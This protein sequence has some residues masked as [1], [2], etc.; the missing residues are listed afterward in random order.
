M[1][2]VDARRKR[3]PIVLLTRKC[4]TT[5]SDNIFNSRYVLRT[6]PHYGYTL[7]VKFWRVST[8]VYIS[9]PV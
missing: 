5:T 6:A 3:V 8:Y 4:H 2:G 9:N 7:T 1:N